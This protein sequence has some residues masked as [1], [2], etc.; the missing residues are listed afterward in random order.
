VDK[1]KKEM[2]E[3]GRVVFCCQRCWTP[4]K[5]DT[6]FSCSLDEHTIAELSLPAVRTPELDYT[7]QASSLDNYVPSRQDHLSIH[8]GFTFVGHA[9]TGNSGNTNIG[10]LSHFIRKSTRLFDLVSS[11][12][13]ID[14]PLC[15]D[16]SDSLLILL[17]QQLFQRYLQL[18]I[19]NHRLILLQYL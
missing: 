9:I 5:L 7:S 10:H 4:L 14:H 1:I 18:S 17:E 13:D 12:S 11:T 16:C 3:D 19:F 2:E 6:G 8:Q 15:E